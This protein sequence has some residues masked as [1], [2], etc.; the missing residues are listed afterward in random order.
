[1]R[2]MSW[3]VAC[4]LVCA[5]VAVAC[6]PYFDLPETKPAKDTLKDM[7]TKTHKGEKS[8][9]ART[10]AELKKDSPDWEQLAK[11]AKAFTDMG[12]ALKS[13]GLYTD[14]SKYIASAADLTKAAK[15]KDHKAASAAFAALTQSCSAC[16]YKAKA[17][18]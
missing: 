7:M 16:H 9:F 12:A 6:G 15:D 2:Q 11:D 8:P 14:P 1:M 3:A 18:E 13:A 5:A 4:V 10:G 17:P